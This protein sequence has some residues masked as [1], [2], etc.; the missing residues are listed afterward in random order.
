VVCSLQPPFD[1]K[2]KKEEVLPYRWVCGAKEK[3]RKLGIKDKR[4]KNLKINMER[5]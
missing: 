4:R 2:K 3:I 1:L 5:N